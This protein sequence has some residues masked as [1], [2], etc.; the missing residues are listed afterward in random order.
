[1]QR[2]FNLLEVIV[3]KKKERGERFFCGEVGFCVF[4]V[5]VLVFGVFFWCV[6]VSSNASIRAHIAY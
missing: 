4:C 6:I 2:I 3:Q 5:W 1:V